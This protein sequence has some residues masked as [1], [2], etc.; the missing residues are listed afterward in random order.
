MVTL[1]VAPDRQYLLRTT[2]RPVQTDTIDNHVARV[3][4]RSEV[5]AARHLEPARVRDAIATAGAHRLP[6]QRTL[7][8][9]DHRWTP[10]V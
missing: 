7:R 2:R 8:V 4:L 5:H 1:N 6:Q 9:A 3:N 10:R